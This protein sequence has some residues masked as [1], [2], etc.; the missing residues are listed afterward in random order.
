MTEKTITS[1]NANEQLRELYETAFPTEEQV[2]WKALLRLIEEMPLDFTA[3]YDKDDEFVGFTIVYPYK[4][5]YWFWYFA[6]RKE[7]RGRGYGQ[8]ILTKLIAKYG[9]KNIILDME[10]P[11]QTDAGNIGQ[12][13][14]RLG[15]YSR[16]G[17][18]DTHAHKTFDGMELTIMMHGN[19][20]FTV[21]DYDAILGNLQRFWSPEGS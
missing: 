10:S 6:V 3:Y 17:F 5:Y 9:N 11:D 16:N 8:Q 7:L 2:P 4:S 13:R 12:R 20:T 18:H 21:Q 14:R 15:F 1:K 19:G